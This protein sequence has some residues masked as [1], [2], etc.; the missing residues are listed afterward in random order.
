MD[1][2]DYTGREQGRPGKIN[3]TYG[4]LPQSPVNLDLYG[5]FFGSFLLSN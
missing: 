5:K 1:D 2:G 4:G 3:N